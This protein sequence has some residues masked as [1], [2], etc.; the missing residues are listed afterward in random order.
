MLTIRKVFDG[1]RSKLEITAEILRQLHTPT[2]KTNI[3]SHCSMSF[4]QSGEYL[5]L[6]TSNDLIRL[7]MM[8]EK[9][10]YQ[11]TET[12]REFLALFNKMVLLLG[13]ATVSSKP[14]IF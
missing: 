8:A 11:R 2:G 1:N 6:M 14:R 3:M 10:T 4:A 9:A 12:G 5:S 13:P 7:D